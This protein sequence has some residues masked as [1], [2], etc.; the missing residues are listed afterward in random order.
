MHRRLRPYAT[1]SSFAAFQP[2]VPS[3][4]DKCVDFNGTDEYMQTDQTS[5]ALG[6]TNQWTIMAWVKPDWSPAFGDTVLELYGNSGNNN[7]IIVKCGG[8][9]ATQFFM[10]IYDSAGSSR[11]QGQLNGVWGDGVWQQIVVT[12]DGTDTGDPFDAYKDGSLLA[13][14]KTQ[15]S[16]CTMTD[17]YRVVVGAALSGVAGSYADCRVHSI[18]MWDDLLTSGEINAIYNG[19]DGASFDL[20]QDSGSYTSS[21]DLSRWWRLGLDSADIGKDYVD[22]DVDLMDNASG[23]TVSN[24]VTDSPT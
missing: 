17:T 9:S 5:T 2:S 14:N 24:I 23:I 21:A 15:N 4:D 20:S 19:G 18:A 7:R 8:A 6:P 12:F 3:E 22:G 10:Q 1:L 11:K 16:S 13:I